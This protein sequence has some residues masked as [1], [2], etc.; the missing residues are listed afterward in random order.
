MSVTVTQLEP[1]QFSQP[2]R[3]FP[4]KTAPPGGVS[5]NY[6]VSRDGTRFLVAVRLPGPAAPWV[7]TT[8]AFSGPR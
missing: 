2:R 4:V 7:V 1:F 6:A 3:L 8:D 5:R